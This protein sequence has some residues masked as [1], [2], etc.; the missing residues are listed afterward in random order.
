MKLAFVSQPYDRLFP[1]TQ[2]SIGLIT[3]YSALELARKFDVTIYGKHYRDDRLPPDLPV[4]VTRLPVNRDRLVQK[5]VR[6]FPRVT[7]GL[8]IAHKLDDHTQYRREVGRRIASDR[9]DIVHVMNYWQWCRELKAPGSSHRLVLE[10]QCEWLSQHDRRAVGRQLEA[11]D[12][13]V[14]VSDH[15]ARTFLGA[16]PDFPGKVTTVGNGVDV[17]HFN[18]AP[19]RGE[20]AEK[21][22]RILFVGR[23]SPEKGVHT[24]LEAFGELA[25]RIDDVEL[26]IAGPQSPLPR[27]FLT[28]LSS[29]RQVRDLLRFYDRDGTCIYGR[30][31]EAA[32]ARHG[33]RDR[34]QFLGNVSHQEL[35]SVYHAA[36]LVVNPSLS[37]SFGIS[38]VEGMACGIPVV[39]THVGGMCETIVSGTT[40]L[41]VEP[42]APRQLAAAL[43]AII[44]DPA[45]AKRM[46]AEGRVR[47]V[48]AYSW[49]ARA[50]RLAALYR[51]LAG[52]S[53]DVQ[54]IAPELRA[55]AR[56]S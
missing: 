6:S 54:P 52:A 27:D 44:D 48:R 37:E 7:G 34:V 55:R 17:D 19:E 53:P 4:S 36:D 24:L 49:K 30:H 15:I 43:T 39:G 32:I 25:D 28:S 16:F 8:G 2:N 22:K 3:Y 45:G 42:E 5:V 46:G 51:S 23:I 13:V 21:R 29:D 38:V 26:V 9:P 20:V 56:A 50:D 18:P 14:A 12:A 47:A 33:L 11:V 1:P 41:L 35:L 31:L 40:G 10:M